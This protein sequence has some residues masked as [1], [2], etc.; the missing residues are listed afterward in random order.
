MYPLKVRANIPRFLCKR[1]LVLCTCCSPTEIIPHI[2]EAIFGAHVQLYCCT[3][4]VGSCGI[5]FQSI[6]AR[7]CLVLSSHLTGR[8]STHAFRY[9][10]LRRCICRG[11]CCWSHTHTHAHKEGVPKQNSKPKHL[12]FESLIHA[13]VYIC[14]FAR[15]VPR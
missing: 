4:L 13:C 2:I 12:K 10:Y 1:G 3:A 11:W 6:R 9:V 14:I 15:G 7:V 8:Q 5:F